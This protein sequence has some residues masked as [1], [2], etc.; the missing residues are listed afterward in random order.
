MILKSVIVRMKC[1]KDPPIDNM[2]NFI[3][4]YFIFKKLINR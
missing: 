2:H 4:F 1:Q 3:L